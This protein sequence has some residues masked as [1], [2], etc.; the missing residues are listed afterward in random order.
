MRL[1]EW[2]SHVSCSSEIFQPDSNFKKQYAG[3]KGFDDGTIKGKLEH[4]DSSSW[5]NKSWVVGVAAKNKK[6]RL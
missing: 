4:R 3:L 5:H 1:G 2:L 6:S